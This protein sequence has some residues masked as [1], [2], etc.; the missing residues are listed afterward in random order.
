VSALLDVLAR[1]R[2]QDDPSL[3]LAAIPYARFL[4]LSASMEGG[5]VLCRMSYDPSLVGNPTLPAIHGGALGALLET[6]AVVQLLWARQALAFP[7]TITLTVDY[8]RSAQAVD[9]LASAEVIRLG[10]RVATV[11]ATA[12]QGDPSR[13]VAATNA[14]FLLP[15]AEG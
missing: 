2:L 15:G 10:R 8:L 1:A 9:T 13:P 4:G 5:R 14:H 12:W 11:R 6:A 3:L 7:K